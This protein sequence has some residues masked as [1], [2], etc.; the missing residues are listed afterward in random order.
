MSGGRSVVNGRHVLFDVGSCRTG[1]PSWELTQG[2][3]V[4][5]LEVITEVRPFDLLVWPI[6]PL[7]TG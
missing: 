1:L 3:S 4:I 2:G 5:P 7:I 6:F